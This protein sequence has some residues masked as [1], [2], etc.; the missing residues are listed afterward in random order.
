[1]RMKQRQQ[2]LQ[3]LHS[4][5]N[6]VGK[7]LFFCESE[8]DQPSLIKKI[9]QQKLIRGKLLA[10]LCNVYMFCIVNCFSLLG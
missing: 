7:K 10:Q 3:V 6:L 1:M 5:S 2:V 4:I 9:S 8:N